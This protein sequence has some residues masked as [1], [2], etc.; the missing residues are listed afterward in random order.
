MPS[1]LRRLEP[2]LWT[3]ILVGLVWAFW[4]T[5]VDMTNRWW[6]DPKYSHGYFVPLFSLWLLWRGCRRAGKSVEQYAQAATWWGL[7]LI[8]AGLALYLSGVFFYLDWLSELALLP[9]LAG[10]CV[11]LGGWSLLGAA[12]WAVAF[13][14]FMLPLPYQVEVLLANPLQRVAT[15]AST[16]LLQMLGVTASSEGNQIVLNSR[17]L[18][19]EEACNGLGMLVTFFALSAGVALV[20]KRPWLDKLVV[21]ASA[22]PVALVAN[23]LRITITG[24]LSETVGG[25]TAMV[26]YH[27]L[28]GYFMMTLALVMIWLELKIWSRLVVEV[29]EESVEAIGQN[30]GFT[31]PATPAPP[32]KQR[33]PNIVL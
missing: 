13:L 14:V 5:L 22:I 19:V 24:V 6:V 25:Q 31:P 33:K 8:A 2:Y 11:C 20:I 9:T 29:P 4:P 18:N 7:P 21:L 15:E 12:G 32:A 28:A 16:F 23:I 10:L 1:P 17:R 30:F 27:D 26:F 3:G